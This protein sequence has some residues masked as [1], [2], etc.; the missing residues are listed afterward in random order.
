[1]EILSS[2]CG[3]IEQQTWKY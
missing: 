2:R 3:N 1:M